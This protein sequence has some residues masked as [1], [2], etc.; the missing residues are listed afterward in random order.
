VEIIFILVC[1][2][3]SI[4]AISSRYEMRVTEPSEKVERYKVSLVR[5][6]EWW[7]EM[8]ADSRDDTALTQL[9]EA[10]CSPADWASKLG[11]MENTHLSVDWGMGLPDRDRLRITEWY[12]E[13]QL[14]GAELLENAV[15]VKPS[16]RGGRAVLK[17]TG[18]TVSQTLVELA[19]SSGVKEVAD[20]F[21][22][23][24]EA[25]AEMLHGL[26]MLLSKPLR[27]R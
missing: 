16:V 15:D 23:N 20:N 14:A 12:I 17:G 25:I 6:L 19:D 7:G 22:L 27:P 8:M 9:V 11:H 26:S 24:P 21:S 13:C 1:I 3:L 4:L 2:W 10:H 5:K 18:F